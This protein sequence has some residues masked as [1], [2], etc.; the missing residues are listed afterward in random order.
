MGR[1]LGHWNGRRKERSQL[2]CLEDVASLCP[3]H[4]DIA[5]GHAVKRADLRHLL[6]VLK[7]AREDHGHDFDWGPVQK[8]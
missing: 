2:P 1:G 4:E 6:P 7:L 5:A 3:D 8:P